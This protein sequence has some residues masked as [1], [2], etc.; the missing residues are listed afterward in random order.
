MDGSGR[1]PT[2]KHRQCRPAPPRAPTVLP[3][4]AQKARQARLPATIC[5]RPLPASDPL[6]HPTPTPRPTCRWPAGCVAGR[7]RRAG[8]GGPTWCWP[9]SGE[10]R[11]PVAVTVSHYNDWW[12]SLGK[13]IVTRCHCRCHFGC[14]QHTKPPPPPLPLPAAARCARRVRCRLGVEGVGDAAGRPQQ[15]PGDAGDDMMMIA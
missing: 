10:P 2:H 4:L 8:S 11:Q 3:H 9:R 6:T 15:Q 1:A 13:A 5:L 7:W 14:R 12:L